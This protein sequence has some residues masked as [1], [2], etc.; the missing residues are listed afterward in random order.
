MRKRHRS[1]I[2]LIIHLIFSIDFDKT[3]RNIVDLLTNKKYLSRQSK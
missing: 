3:K 2:N 1:I